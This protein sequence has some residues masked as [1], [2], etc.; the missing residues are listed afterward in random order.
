MKVL[1]RITQLMVA[2]LTAT[3]LNQAAPVN[4]ESLA[5]A[6]A[7]AYEHSGLLDQNR[8]VLRAADEDVAVAVSKL[9]PILVWSGGVT[10]SYGR[11]TTLGAAGWSTNS[12]STTDATLSLGLEL[13]LYDGGRTKMGV[14]VAKESVLATRQALI[15]VEQQVLLGAVQAYMAV[16]SSHEI[17]SLRRNNVRVI[18]EEL[19]AAKNRFDVG[20]V[21]RT[22]VALTEARLAGA[23]SQLMQAKG[24]LAV[25]IEDYRATVGHKPGS[26]TAPPALRSPARSANAAND[27]ALRTHP[28][29]RAVQHEVA[30]AELG[31]K[32][33]RTS[34]SPTVTLKG[35]LSA[36]ERANSPYQQRG[37]NIGI[38]L[39]GPIYQ[40]GQFRALTRQAIA[41]RDAVRSKL[42]HTRI[43]IT[44][45]VGSAFSRWQ[46]AQAALKATDQQI[47]AAQVAFRGVREEASL[48]ART[49]LDVLN[50]EQELLD[51][52]ALRISAASNQ[53]V[54]YYGLLASMG[55]LTADH[56]KLNVQ[57][58]DPAAYY[59]MVKDAPSA[60]SERGRKLDQ[61]LRAIGKP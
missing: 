50:A 48:G 1:R 60:V 46:V 27:I 52:R 3:V 40:G 39:G 9:R 22:D 38:N 43:Q 19:R 53:Y 7:S 61:A 14:E 4:A 20:E 2:G 16:R 51:A 54:A 24:D 13:L 35:G 11:A 6:M 57:Q 12:A 25:A 18:K 56:L 28:Q 42:H 55:L 5:D 59:N 58:Y 34:K 15:G 29:I 47:R 41:Q 37:A 44:Q 21:T 32:M 36:T 30:A 8:A 33:A 17:V 45:S 49:T 26:L 31:V 23:Q 10:R